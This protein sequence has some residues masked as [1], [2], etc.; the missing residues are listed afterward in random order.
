MRLFL[1][2]VFV[3]ALLLQTVYPSV[4]CGVAVGCC[5][6]AEQSSGQV[7]SVENAAEE[8]SC[9][10]L[11]TQAETEQSGCHSLVGPEATNTADCPCCEQVPD[12]AVPVVTISERE[13][14]AAISLESTELLPLPAAALLAKSQYRPPTDDVTRPGRPSRCHLLDCVWLL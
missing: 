9:C 11:P 12:Q 6:N 3:L 5:C 4:E 1:A 10:A 7:E 14:D 8:H 2:P 13:L